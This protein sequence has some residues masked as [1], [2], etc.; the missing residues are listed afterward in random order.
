[1]NESNGGRGKQFWI[2]IAAGVA[3]VA[4]GAVL[5]YAAFGAVPSPKG[6]AATPTVGASTP[7]GTA[8]AAQPSAS[9]T[10]V[11]TPSATIVTSADGIITGVPKGTYVTI[12]KWM[13]KNST[14]APDAASYAAKQSRNGYTVVA[15]DGDSV[16]GL[17]AGRYAI[18]VVGATT[19]AD[20]KAVCEGLG[21]A[22][23]GRVCWSRPVTG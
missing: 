9:G 7:A 1:M 19:F 22:P 13:D 20:S 17:D 6:P 18:G 15:I 12:F 3:G 4:V 23:D 16:P 21:L 2:G 10:A 5:V 8:G 11:Q 14:S